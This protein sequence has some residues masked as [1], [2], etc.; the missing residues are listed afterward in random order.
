MYLPGD[1]VPMFVA[2]SAGNPRYHFDTVAGRYVVIAFLGSSLHPVAA[3]ALQQVTE[4]LEIFDDRHL[5]FFGVSADPD[6]RNEGR[7]RQRI[8]GIRYFWDFDLGIGRLFGATDTTS[9]EAAELRT[10]G[11]MRYRQFWL[12]L[13]PMLRVL[14]EAPLEH[15]EAVMRF[16]RAL[17]PVATHAGVECFAPVLI[18]P[19]VFEPEFCRRLIDLY[20]QNGGSESGFMREIDGKTVGIYDNS[21]KRRR[22][23]AITE[24]AIRAA[25]RARIVRR[26]V[27][28]IERAFQFRVTRMERYI[29][30]CYDG[31]AGGYF[32]AHRDNTTR[33]TAHRKFAVTMNLNAEDYEGGE[34]RF[35][36]FGQR[37]YRAPTGGAVVFSCSLL[38]EATPVSAGRRYAFLPFLYDDAAA[39]VRTANRH[40]LAGAAQE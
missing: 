24:E 19:R 7:L 13:D 40:F 17:P 22:D 34:L 20:E 37:T 8:P 27:P 31:E 3:A 11:A 9:P 18:L 25:A 12:V 14:L 35:P 33:G 1:P 5:A 4:A 21:Y 29:V 6:D 30:A 26:L 23:Y 36:E 16:L 2:E 32:R 39:E 15:G 38:H 10:T 28:E